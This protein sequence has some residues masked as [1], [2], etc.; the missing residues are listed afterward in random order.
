MVQPL[1]PGPSQAPGSQGPLGTGPNGPV[2]NPSLALVGESI[3]VFRL[4]ISA[5]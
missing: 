5:L 3:G 1:S 4:N 2:S